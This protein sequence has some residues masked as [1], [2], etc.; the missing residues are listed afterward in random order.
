MKTK[1][2]VRV[3]ITAL[4]SLGLVAGILAQAQAARGT[5]I[6]HETN[7]HTAKDGFEVLDEI[8]KKH[9]NKNL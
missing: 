6:V 7:P 8:A 2:T 5:V 1:H 9:Q 4:A 3:A